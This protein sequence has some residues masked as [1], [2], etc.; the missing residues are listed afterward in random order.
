[1]IFKL[2]VN[3][4]HEERG[5]IYSF[6]SNLDEYLEFSG[7]WGHPFSFANFMFILFE[8]GK[9]TD[10]YRCNSYGVNF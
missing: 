5:R 7:K 3:K 10:T 9:V 1:M 6:F 2:T 4:N 8:F